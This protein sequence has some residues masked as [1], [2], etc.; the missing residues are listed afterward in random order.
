MK[1]LALLLGSL[2]VV[3]SIASAKEVMPAPTPEPEKVIEYVEKPVIVYKESE[4]KPAW[5]PNG[6]VDL[7]FTWYGETENKNPGEDTDGDW[8]R[9][10]SNSG[11][12]QTTVN[13]NFT[14]KQNLN[15]RSR[16]YNA[17]RNTESKRAGISS[18]N[19]RIRHHYNFGK[20]GDSKVTATSRLEYNQTKG[21][22]GLKQARASVFFDFADYFPSNEYFKV[23]TFGLRP[24]YT[25]RWYRHNSGVEGQ[26]FS[27]G[28][29]NRYT[30]DFESSYKLPLGFSADLNLYSGYDRHRKSFRV[31]N[32]GETKKGQFFGAMELYLNQKTVLYKKGNLELDF[33]FYSGYDT[34]EFRQYKVF[35]N[36]DKVVL[37]GGTKS[38]SKYTDKRSYSLY[39]LPNVQLNYKAT[40][41]VKLYVGAGA[42]YRNW[43][44]DTESNAK[45]WRWQPTAWA[46]MRISF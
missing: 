11:R 6:S 42:E 5:R 31:G 13:I 30:L 23:E 20:L 7:R 26:S 45:N 33:L 10:R 39:M 16:T 28:T 19:L 25:H 41:F 36:G 46:G 8:A 37:P 18:D 14:E 22:E 35:S 40:D 34:Y 27:A 12:L 17:F 44:V 38:V 24:G 29:A 9:G 1:R 32:D 2:L 3:S 4:V 43:A 15:I 21:D